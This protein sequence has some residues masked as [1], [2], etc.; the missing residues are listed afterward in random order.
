MFSPP[1]LPAEQ[2]ICSAAAFLFIYF[3]FLMSHW[4]PIT[5]QNVPNQSHQI[6][7][8]GRHIGEDEWSDLLFLL[9]EGTLLW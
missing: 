5:N 7:R 6:F 3:S 1:G 8:N 2:A 9:A 4:R